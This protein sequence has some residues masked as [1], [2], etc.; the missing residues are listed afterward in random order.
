[1]RQ[2]TIRAAIHLQKLGCE[3]G[4]IFGVVAKNSH[5]VAPIVYASFCIGC[6]INTLDPSF[7]KSEL[8]H[9]LS[10]TQPKIVFCDANIY[11]LVQNCLNDLENG[12]K[13]YTFSGQSGDSNAVE[14]LFEEIDG[15]DTFW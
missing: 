3:K 1:M 11:E 6:P 15:E 13:V 4:D 9:M 12:A 7:S 2:Q 10:I 14:N 5:Y 8:V